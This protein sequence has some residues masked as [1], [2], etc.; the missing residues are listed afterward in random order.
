MVYVDNPLKKTK[1]L[2][3]CRMGFAF[4]NVHDRNWGSRPSAIVDNAMAAGVIHCW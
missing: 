1:S 4:K 2:R 3:G